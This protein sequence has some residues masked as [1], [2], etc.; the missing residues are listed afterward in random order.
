M[1]LKPIVAVPALA[2]ALVVAGCGSAASSP[3]P[4]PD[5]ASV[6]TAASKAT[7]PTKLE[8]T[9][10][11]SYTEAGSTTTLPDNALKVDVDTS[12]GVGS[13]HI[14]LPS[15]L[16]G[17]DGAAMLKTLG[18][19]GDSLT[20]DALYDGKALY[21]KSPL[22]PALLTQLS[23]LAP[24][25]TIPTLAADAWARLVDEATLKEL[26]SAAQ[27]AVESAA[28]SGSAAAPSDMKAALDK[29]GATMT[30]GDQTTGAG[31]PAND[32]KITIDPA[33]AKAYILAHPDE[34][35]TTQ[36]QQLSA[37]GDLSTF[38]ADVLVDVAT[39]RVEQVSVTAGGTQSGK[40]VSFT[41]K[42]GIGEAP[43][44]VSFAAPSGA[45]D[46]PIVQILGPIV[47]SMFGGGLPGASSAP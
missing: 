12:A 9:L 21:A 41:L 24:G 7:Y 23:S 40:D 14:A 3:T 13:V 37:I 22:L 33:K 42:V 43:S 19:T 27:G 26:T 11:G 16:L 46:V 47:G 36:V 1:R 10:S 45:V 4:P 6:M 34:F 35:P 18:V 20:V 29:I 30:L 25:T 44:S 17:T 8:I 28:P 38:S 2:V 31:G 15:S 32:V 39:S 5:A